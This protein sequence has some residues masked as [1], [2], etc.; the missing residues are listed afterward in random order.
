MHTAQVMQ[1]GGGGGADTAANQAQRQPDG[2]GWMIQGI[3]HQTRQ[4]IQCPTWPLEWVRDVPLGPASHDILLPQGQGQGK[5]A[6]PFP[7]FPVQVQWLSCTVVGVKHPPGHPSTRWQPPPPGVPSA[8]PAAVSKLGQWTLT[9]PACI[10]PQVP[11]TPAAPG[12]HASL[13]WQAQGHACAS[14]PHPPHQ[15]PSGLI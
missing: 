7:S 4:G 6:L 8:R 12:P 1:H 11:H 13:P 15:A 2:K 5:G 10:S 3:R 14:A 9:Q